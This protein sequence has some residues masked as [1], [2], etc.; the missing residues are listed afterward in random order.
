MTVIVPLD[1][2]DAMQNSSETTIIIILLLAIMCMLMFRQGKVKRV[3]P[4]VSTMGSLD[5]L[6]FGNTDI[7]SLRHLKL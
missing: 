7:P 6:A 3:T 4:V 1:D 5:R 2:T